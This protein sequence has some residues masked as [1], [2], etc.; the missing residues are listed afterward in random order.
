MFGLE[1]VMAVIKILCNIAFAI[2]TAIPAYIAW[3]CV[4]PIY[5]TFLPQVYL[6]I[7]YWQMVAILLVITYVGEQ[8]SKLTPT[9]I[10]ISTK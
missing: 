1:Y 8:I 5:L 4:A 2:V 7:P 3:N 9:I 10:S 6:H